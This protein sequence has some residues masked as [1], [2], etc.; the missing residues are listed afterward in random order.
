MEGSLTQLEE[1]YLTVKEAGDLIGVSERTI[2]RW[3]NLG[4]GPPRIKLGRKVRIARTS[5]E[6]WMRGK[7]TKPC[8]EQ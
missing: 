4:Y 5:L 7:E 1:Q 3:H 2:M 8:R 6:K